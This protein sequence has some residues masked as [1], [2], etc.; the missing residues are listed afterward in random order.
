MSIVPYQAAPHPDIRVYIFPG[1][2][3]LHRFRQLN[4]AKT[5]NIT[6]YSPLQPVTMN[7]KILPTLD[8]PGDH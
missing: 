1:C 4:D 3:V 2:K 7:S 5:R 8:D 6:P